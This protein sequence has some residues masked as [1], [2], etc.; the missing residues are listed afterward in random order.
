MP[1]RSRRHALLLALALSLAARGLV[2]QTIAVGSKNFAESRFLGELFAQI[3]EEKTDL[4]VERRLGLAGTEFVFEALRTG[5]IDIYPEY[6]GT[7]L[8]TILGRP[9]TGAPSEALGEVRRSFLERWDLHWLAP[10]GFANS[11]VVAVRRELAERHDL[12]TISDLAAVDPPL[13]G[14]FGPEFQERADGLPG[15]ESTYGLRFASTATMQEALKYRAA[16]DG[17][18]DVIDAYATD[19]RLLVFELSPLEDD[20]GFFPPYDAAPLVR[21][22]TLSR[23]PEIGSALALLGGAFDEASM[24]QINLRLQEGKE[25]EARVAAEVLQ[26]LGLVAGP[27]PGSEGGPTRVT[28]RITGAD[29]AGWTGRHL[30]L[31]LGALLL[32]TLVAVPLGLVLER[33]RGAAEGAIRVVGTSQTIPSLAL[34]GFLIP[35]FGVGV[36]PAIVALWIYSLFPI[37]RNTY[38]GVRDADPDAVEA[39]TALGMTEGQVLRRVRLPLA[40]PT[41]MAGVRTAG[42]ITVGTATLAAF[43]GAGGLGEPIIAGVQLL[44]T[45]RILAGAIPAALLAV[46]VDTGLG[47]LERSLTPKGLR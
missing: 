42:V 35:V 39:A 7:G 33:H 18:V 16:G 22:D 1:R 6:T 15:M 37:L 45:Q 9:S 40:V 47:T 25:P 44:D 13:R 23:H 4:E 30:L 24:R 34:L 8:V 41:I 5:S 2:A 28:R 27:A 43:I 31:S 12:R 38:T 3:I 32:G 36:L 26:S 14:A 20:L 10:L 21:G 46:A 29:I 17:E 19:G 11:W